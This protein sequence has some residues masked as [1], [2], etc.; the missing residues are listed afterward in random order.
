[1]QD[2][3]AGDVGDFLKFALLR[4]LIAAETTA[5][6]LRLGV[7]WYR[8]ADEDHNAD[9]KHIAYLTAQHRAA[10]HLRALDTD[11]YDRLARI[12]SGPERTVQAVQRTELVGPDACFFSDLLD[13]SDLPRVARAERAARRTAWV[14]RAVASVSSCDLVFLDPDNGV[15]PSRHAKPRHRTKAVKH[16]YLDELLPYAERG[17]SVVAYHHADRKA[18]VEA[19][20]RWRLAELGGE[21]PVEPLA[22]VRASRGTTRLFLVGAVAAQRQRL[23]DRLRS[24]ETGRW[25]EELR[26]LWAA[27]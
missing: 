10:Q 24:L 9:G 4:H 5:P 23:L 17:Q 27:A 16:T 6:P 21:V 12:V 14:E 1:M 18:K 2:R 8:T 20:A 11:L 25:R 7:V 15:R 19:Q 26:V 22:A 13:F 3:Y